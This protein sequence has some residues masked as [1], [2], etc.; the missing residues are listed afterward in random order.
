MGARFEIEACQFLF[1]PP[2]LEAYRAAIHPG[3]AVG[4]QAVDQYRQ[5]PA[6]GF[7]RHREG[8][9]VSAQIAIPAPR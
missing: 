6:H 8:G 7:D 1:G 4:E 2:P 3:L 9:Q 5:V